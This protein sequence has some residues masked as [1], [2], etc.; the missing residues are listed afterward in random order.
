M[1]RTHE[2]PT[3]E[4]AVGERLY[5]DH[6]RP[7]TRRIIITIAS[8][9]AAIAAV[10]V[11]AALLMGTLATNTSRSSRSASTP[12]PKVVPPAVI[13]SSTP[14]TDVVVPVK[15][16]PTPV[17][18]PSPAPIA[19]PTPAPP[20][21]TGVVVIDPGHQ[22]QGDSSLEPEGPG[23]SV[24]KPKV[25]DGATGVATHVAE[26]Q[27]NLEIALKLQQAL[28]ARGVTVVMV[29]TSQNVNISNSAR[30]AIANNANAA[31]FIRLHCDGIGNSSTNGFSTLVPASNQWTGPIVA[32]SRK[33]AG[34]VHRAAIAATG[35]GDR[36]IVSRGDLSGFNWSKVP[37]ILPEMGFLSNPTEDRKLNT[38]AYQQQ[39]ANGMADGIVQYLKSR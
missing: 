37:T 2:V 36:G 14:E 23:S 11:V 15:P 30:A 10:I 31:L 8:I 9:V 21:V 25:A 16:A 32:S 13:E 1:L 4:K 26:S 29:R 35:A 34:Y 12:A 6:D 5:N 28:V 20:T 27:V 38:A 7:S 19:A 22:G 18:V 39:L 24:R 17:P 3:D 33:A